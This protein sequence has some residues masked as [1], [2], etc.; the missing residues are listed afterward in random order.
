MLSNGTRVC[1][2]Y[3]GETKGAP[4]LLVCPTLLGV[5]SPAFF[6]EVSDTFYI[7]CRVS[8]EGGY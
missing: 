5:D 4:A 8:K 7:V 1:H 3:G 6:R 2:V